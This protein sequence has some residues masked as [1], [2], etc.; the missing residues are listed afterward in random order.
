[1]GLG[2]YKCSTYYVYDGAASESSPRDSFEMQIPRL[3]YF[4]KF[5]RHF[6]SPF[7]FYSITILEEP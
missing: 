5:S 2:S 6:A 1:M 3:M 4:E 7:K